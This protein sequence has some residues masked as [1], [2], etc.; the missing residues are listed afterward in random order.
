[1]NKDND[2]FIVIPAR[3]D[4]K[5]LPHKNRKLLDYTINKI[6]NEIR[7]KVIVTTNDEIIIEK[8]SNSGVK[9]L[10]REERLSEDTTSMKDVMIDVIEKFQ[11]KKNMT[12]I[13]L[14]L[15]SPNREYSDIEKIFQFY[16][17]NNYKTLTCCVEPKTHPY[18]CLLKKDNG[19]G[20]QIT[21]HD[22][23]RRQDYPECFEL[24]HFV[25]IFQVSEINNL[26]KNM[27]NADT[28]FYQIEHDVDIDYENELNQFE[29]QKN[30]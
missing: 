29:N 23:Y 21:S 19:K 30:N 6:P 17:K 4:S 2:V 10:K 11:I 18:L 20:E 22:L 3:R 13:M 12:I 24:S 5:G 8:L 7:E 9:I 28:Y 1:M 14:Y 27:Y 25:C 16:S 26:N 15:T